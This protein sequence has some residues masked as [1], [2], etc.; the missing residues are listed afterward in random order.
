MGRYL[1]DIH[2]AQ[3]HFNAVYDS[4][5]K[6][7]PRRTLTLTLSQKLFIMKPFNRVTLGLAHVKVRIRSYPSTTIGRATIEGA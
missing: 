7:K 1:D 4:I 5:L 6:T 3:I 2:L